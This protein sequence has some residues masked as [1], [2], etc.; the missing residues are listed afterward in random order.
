MKDV[1]PNASSACVHVQVSSYIAARLRVR[2]NSS[3]PAFSGDEN[4]CG[5]E[6]SRLVGAHSVNGVS[7]KNAGSCPVSGALIA[8]EGPVFATGVTGMAGAT[9]SRSE[10]NSRSGSFNETGA[11]DAICTVFPL[12]ARSTMLSAT[13][14]PRQCVERNVFQ[15]SDYSTGLRLDRVN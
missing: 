2:M 11:S 5:P 6:T 9:R 3:Y 14:V 4:S 1:F 8:G 7:D 13:L 12:W 10:R 15:G